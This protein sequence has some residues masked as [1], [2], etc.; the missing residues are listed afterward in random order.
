[1]L[2]FHG[3]QI[4]LNN[5]KKSSEI[6][7]K[8]F[9]GLINHNRTGKINHFFKNK[10]NAILL[11]IKKDN[12]DNYKK[13]SFFSTDKFNFFGWSASDHGPRK[14]GTNKDDLYEYILSLITNSS[15]DKNK[16]KDIKLLTFPKV[17]GYGFNPLSVYFCYNSTNL[18]VHTVFEVKNTFG[19]I[20]HYV[21]KNTDKKVITQRVLKKLFVSPFY[22]KKGYYNLY[23]NHIDK[24]IITSV[25]YVMN[26]NTVFFASMN[27]KEIQ[28]NNLNILKSI[29]KLIVFPG[30][31]WI[32]I[33]LQAFLLW[34]KKARIYKV[35]KSETIKHSFGNHLPKDK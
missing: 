24:K 26:N 28:F 4:K 13:P 21:L 32:N 23:A 31:I 15:Y 12:N 5:Y 17:F 34:L 22:N 11:D 29:C 19:D 16:I 1:M 20:H 9:E 8:L 6:N 7:I 27:L 3:T 2:K 33:H 30:K 14:K 18:L 35:P 10:I 25:E